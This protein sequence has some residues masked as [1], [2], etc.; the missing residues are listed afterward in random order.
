M[1][2][3]T[4]ASSNLEFSYDTFNNQP[5]LVIKIKGIPKKRYI[6]HE[7]DWSNQN[8]V[9]IIIPMCALPYVMRNQKKTI[10]THLK[11]ELS[12]IEA[13]KKAFSDPLELSSPVIN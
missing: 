4:I 8:E 13:M 11:N 1:R 3:T 6:S 5:H 10:T 2:K 7:A 12:K 9:E